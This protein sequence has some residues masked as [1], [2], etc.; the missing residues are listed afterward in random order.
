VAE[1]WPYAELRHGHLMDFDWWDGWRGYSGYDDIQTKT[2]RWGGESGYRAEEPSLYDI[3]HFKWVDQAFGNLH[4][5]LEFWSSCTTGSHFGPIVYLSHGA[6][7]WMGAAGST[8]GIQ[9]DLHN[10]WMF[11]D[12]L[13]KG[14]SIGES[15]SR[16]LWMFNR[17]FTTKDPTTLYGPSTLFQLSQG[18]LTNVNVLFGDP[19]MTC[20]APDWTEPIPTLP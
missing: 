17:D 3:I 15:H 13:V 11:Y 16:Y 8:Y 5:E 10:N 7:M 20:Y 14:E 1:Q 2:P 12:V 6:A 19:T 18:G 4:S 9:D